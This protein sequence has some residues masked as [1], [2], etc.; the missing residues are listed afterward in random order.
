MS[1]KHSRDFH[2]D[3][4]VIASKSR[5][6]YNLF[7]EDKMYALSNISCGF[8]TE[9]DSNIELF[10]YWWKLKQRMSRYF[11]KRYLRRD[12]I[13]LEFVYKLKCHGCSNCLNEAALKRELN[14]L[15]TTVKSTSGSTTAQSG[16]T[17]LRLFYNKL[18]NVV[19]ASKSKE[20][21]TA[22]AQRERHK[23]EVKT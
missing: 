22:L 14:E 13:K 19:P 11:M 10:R 23:K 18:V 9:T 21:P 4:I 15:V 6:A 20:D 1:L 5:S 8:L 2:T 3:Q 7:N 17:L 16:S 12:P